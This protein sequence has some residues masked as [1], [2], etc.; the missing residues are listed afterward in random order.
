MITKL[1][2]QIQLPQVGEMAPAFEVQT[3]KGVV[4]FPE[5]SKGSWCVFFAHPVNFT[6]AWRMYSNFLAMKERWLH[7][8]NTRLLV[9][10]NE[11]ARQ[12][13][14]SDVVRRYIGI[15]LKAPVI[16]DTDNRISALYGLSPGRRIVPPNHRLLY[17]IDPE[18]VIRLIVNRPLASLQTSMAYLE[19]ELDRLQGRIAATVETPVAPPVVIPVPEQV[20]T[21]AGYKPK[22]AYFRQSRIILN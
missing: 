3:Q 16:E 10:T 9:L 7:E 15:F 1:S 11:S 6:S 21:Q 12:S 22:P 8:R 18:G 14:W 19:A 2:E 17:I 13:G 4:R 5:F 20:D